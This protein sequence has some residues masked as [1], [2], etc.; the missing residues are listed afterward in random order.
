[1]KG[2]VGTFWCPQHGRATKCDSTENQRKFSPEKRAGMHRTGRVELK[3]G[4]K[5][6][7]DLNDPT[8]ASVVGTIPKLFYLHSPELPKSRKLK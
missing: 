2:D 6:E 4:S 8:A 7:P 5:A 3:S 1:M